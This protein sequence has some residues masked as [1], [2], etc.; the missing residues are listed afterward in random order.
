MRA[1]QREDIMQEYLDLLGD[2]RF[3][4]LR[5]HCLC[6]ESIKRIGF[7]SIP[8][9]KAVVRNLFNSLRGQKIAPHQLQ[10]LWSSAK[11]VL[12][13]PNSWNV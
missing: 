3:R 5:I 12:L 10:N 4:T 2:T 6:L 1:L 7:T 13:D 9:S 8:W 11:F